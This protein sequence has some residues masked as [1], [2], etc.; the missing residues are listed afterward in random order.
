MAGIIPFPGNPPAY[1]A[2]KFGIL[3]LS[4]L[5]RIDLRRKGP[6]NVGASILFPGHTRSRINDTS[7]ALSPSGGGRLEE[8]EFMRGVRE[9]NATGTD[10][11]LVG[12]RV[13]RAIR[14]DEF[15]I[16]SHPEY[17]D[18]VHRH[19]QELLGSFADP[20]DPTRVDQMPKEF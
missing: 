10:P 17:R 6:S 4:E 18:R 13:L 2:S 8:S 3:G 9:R 20:A 7:A 5:L 19:Y 12:E 14:S 15:Y 11:R 1:T 16:F